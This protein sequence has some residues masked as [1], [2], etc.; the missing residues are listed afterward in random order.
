MPCLFM[1][2]EYAQSRGGNVAWSQ[3]CSP[4]ND[5]AL[6]LG[7]IQIWNKAALGRYVWEINAKKENLWIKWV[8]EVYIRNED[9]WVIIL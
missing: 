5:D 8:N 1:A 2:L 3:I 7:K 4:K 6:G 9:W